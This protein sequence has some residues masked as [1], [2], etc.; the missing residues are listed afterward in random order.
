MILTAICNTFPFIKYCKG[1]LIETRHFLFNLVFLMF[2]LRH[3]HKL[4]FRHILI[5]LLRP[6][7][8]HALFD[9]GRFC[10]DGQKNKREYINK[11]E[12]NT[13]KDYLFINN[14]YIWT[15]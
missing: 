12:R 5:I 15:Q 2:M 7:S 11:L 13:C 14:G 9:N 3:V 10:K 8:A 6:L 1:V 4:S